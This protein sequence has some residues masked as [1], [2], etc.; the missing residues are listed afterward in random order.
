MKALVWH[1]TGDVRIDNVSDP[2]IVDPTDAV[3]RSTTTCICGSDLHLYNGYMPTPEEGDILGHEPMPT[4]S[5]R[6]WRMPS[7]STSGRRRH[8]RPAGQPPANSLGT[9]WRRGIQSLSRRRRRADAQCAPGPGRARIVRPRV[10][11]PH[12]CRSMPATPPRSSNRGDPWLSKPL[13]TTSRQT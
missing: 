2:A 8:S 6:P 7:G 4:G 1:K 11:I 12:R 9:T 5:K 13:S 3:I 10:S